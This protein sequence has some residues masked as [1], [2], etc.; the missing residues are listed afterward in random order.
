[1]T[2]PDTYLTMQLGDQPLNRWLARQRLDDHAE[3]AIAKATR[4]AKEE[5][6]PRHP[7]TYHQVDNAEG[8]PVQVIVGGHPIVNMQRHHW[9]PT[10]IT[11]LD[12]IH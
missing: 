7:N 8:V 12:D 11:E 5:S 4:E 1:M 2:Q 6:A 3:Q 10:R 9:K